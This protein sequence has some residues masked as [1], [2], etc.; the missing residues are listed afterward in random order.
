MTSRL[1]SQ[2]AGTSAAVLVAVGGPAALWAVDPA[3]NKDSRPFDAGK[4]LVITYI[5]NLDIPGLPDRLEQTMAADSQTARPRSICIGQYSDGR[6]PVALFDASG[7]QCAYESWDAAGGTITA[8]LSCKPPSEAPG[9]IRIRLTGTYRPDRFA[10]RSLTTA[11]DADGNVQLR[12]SS[13]V[14]AR[15]ASSCSDRTARSAHS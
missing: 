4:W 1:R 2:I 8:V 12:M 3:T 10:L 5:D 11:R 13:L 7:A 6:P 14:S 15:L 9:T